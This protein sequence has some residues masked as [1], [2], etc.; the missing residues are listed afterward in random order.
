M[1]MSL[2][3]PTQVTLMLM[4]SPPTFDNSTHNA[5]RQHVVGDAHQSMSGTA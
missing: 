2:S 4:M 1:A 3:A 5:V